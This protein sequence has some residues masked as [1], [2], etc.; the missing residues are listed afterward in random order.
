MLLGGSA[1]L[2]FGWYNVTSRSNL[3]ATPTIR[4]PGAPSGRLVDDPHHFLDALDTVYRRGRNRN[5][6][7]GGVPTFHWLPDLAHA[8]R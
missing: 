4:R 6:G 3:A 5:V 2:S 7:M 8:H 1:K